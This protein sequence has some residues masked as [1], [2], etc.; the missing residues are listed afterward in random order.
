MNSCHLCTIAARLGRDVAW[1]PK[2]EKTGDAQS[3]SFTA[4]EQRKGF[5][6]PRG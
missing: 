3:Q 4:R 6:I 1:D 5:E 2:A